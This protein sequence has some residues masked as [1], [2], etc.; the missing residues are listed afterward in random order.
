MLPFI[1]FLVSE[2]LV[3]EDL[4]FAWKIT[5]HSK[6]ME[7]IMDRISTHMNKNETGKAK[8][9][10]N[11]T[12]KLSTKRQK[13][14]K[15]S[16]RGEDGCEVIKCFKSDVLASDT[17]DEKGLG[18]WRR[19]VRLS[20]KENKEKRLSWKKKRFIPITRSILGHRTGCYE[21]ATATERIV[22]CSIAA[23]KEEE[24]FWKDDHR[25]YDFDVTCKRKKCCWL[26]KKEFVFLEQGYIIPFL[27]DPPAF[28]R[29]KITSYK[30]TSLFITSNLT[31]GYH[32]DDIFILN[33]RKYLGFSTSKIV[34]TDAI[35]SG[36][37]G[38]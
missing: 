29:K 7:R 9:A 12:K 20:K 14:I 18:K 25:D 32:H 2:V 16:D 3:K 10:V 33:I 8:E 1:A 6:E 35:D 17:D 13:L 30:I 23:Q 27:T 38:F 24:F 22:T 28:L 5:Q 11:E 26:S 36:Y 19:Q 21:Y 31:S 15:K 34:F 4:L 37:G